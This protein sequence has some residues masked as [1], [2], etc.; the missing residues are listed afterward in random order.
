MKLTKPSQVLEAAKVN[1][2]M[3]VVDALLEVQAE[4]HMLRC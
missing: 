2:A 1:L 4:A 3:N